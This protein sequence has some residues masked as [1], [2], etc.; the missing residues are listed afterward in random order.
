[1]RLKQEIRNCTYAPAGVHDAGDHVGRRLCGVVC[2][3]HPG[4]LFL[5]GAIGVNPR[6]RLLFFYFRA[7]DMQILRCNGM[8]AI[9]IA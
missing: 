3:G 4:K 5:D 2:H 8:A 1:M 7:R 9:F 6:K